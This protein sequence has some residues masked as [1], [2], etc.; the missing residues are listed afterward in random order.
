MKE[1]FDELNDSEPDA[2]QLEPV[3]TYFEFMLLMSRRRLYEL[4]P[5]SLPEGEQPET[6]P[7]PANKHWLD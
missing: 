4:A 6:S 5:D 3:Y 7:R 1:I 2:T